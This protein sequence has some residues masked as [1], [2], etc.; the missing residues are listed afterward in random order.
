MKPRIDSNPV[1]WQNIRDVRFIEIQG[2]HGVALVS[3]ASRPDDGAL[4]VTVYDH[5]HVVVKTRSAPEA[6][7]GA[8]DDL[9]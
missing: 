6:P 3:F 2:D 1:A 5:P 4:V 9:V 8:L 7:R